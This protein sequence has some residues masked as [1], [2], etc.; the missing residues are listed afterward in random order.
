MRGDDAMYLSKRKVAEM[1]S[2]RRKTNFLNFLEGLAF[3]TLVGLIAGMLFAPQ[4][5]ND[6][7]LQLKSQAEDAYNKA[8]T[9]VKE[10][11]PAKCETIEDEESFIEE[12]IEDDEED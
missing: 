12:F 10:K 3:G 1:E 6:S 2:Y 4:S 9:T 8:K 7:R 5:G 11:L